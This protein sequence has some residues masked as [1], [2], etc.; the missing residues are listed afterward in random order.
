MWILTTVFHHPWNIQRSSI[1]KTSNILDLFHH[2]TSNIIL[3][4]KLQKHLGTSRNQKKH[5]SFS[6][7]PHTSNQCHFPT[8]LSIHPGGG[9]PAPW[10][11]CRIGSGM[12][13]QSLPCMAPGGSDV[14]KHRKS[15]ALLRG[16]LRGGGS[17][18][19][20]LIH[21]AFWLVVG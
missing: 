13:S 18:G 2:P 4:L 3:T 19:D 12:R 8:H 17:R 7:P 5:P 1:L 15:S 16:E 21:C 11:L 9:D 10:R 20:R 14:K 6:Y